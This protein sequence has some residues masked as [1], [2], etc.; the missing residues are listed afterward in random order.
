MIGGQHWTEI[1]W[2]GLNLCQHSK[3]SEVEQVFV[4]LNVGLSGFLHLGPVDPESS[5]F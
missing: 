4:L 5:E 3:F 2:E 1:C